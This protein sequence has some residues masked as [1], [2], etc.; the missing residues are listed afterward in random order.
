MFLRAE[1]AALRRGAAAEKRGLRGGQPRS[2]LARFPSQHVAQPD[3]D[4]AAIRPE[5]LFSPNYR[6]KL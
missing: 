1:P 2:R 6:S 4:S 5:R 3:P